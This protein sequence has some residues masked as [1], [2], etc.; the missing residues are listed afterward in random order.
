M[1]FFPLFHCFRQWTHLQNDSFWRRKKKRKIAKVSLSNFCKEIVSP[2]CILCG[3]HK[4]CILY[5]KRLIRFN[6]DFFF[7]FWGNYTLSLFGYVYS[8]TSNEFV[9]N[10]LMNLTD[11]RIQIAIYLLWHGHFGGGREVGPPT[12]GR[13]TEN[14]PSEHEHWLISRQPKQPQNELVIFSGYFQTRTHGRG[15]ERGAWAGASRWAQGNVILSGV[16]EGREQSPLVEVGGRGRGKIQIFLPSD[17]VPRKNAK[18][19]C[20]SEH[21]TLSRSPA[22]PNSLTYISLSLFLPLQPLNLA[23]PTQEAA[24]LGAAAATAT[25]WTMPSRRRAADRS[26][27]CASRTMSWNVSISVTRS[28]CN[29]SRCWALWPSLWCSAA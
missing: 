18:T 20:W 14:W 15:K 5:A 16:T 9:H 2:F 12:C 6:D 27:R 21:A 23:P 8:E 19:F 26:I 10:I 7:C 1:F 22:Q 29:A 4:S 13:K 24:A 25:A 11:C 3:S 17:C 28:S